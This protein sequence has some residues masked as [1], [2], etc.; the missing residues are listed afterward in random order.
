MD[1]SLSDLN[2]VEAYNEVISRFNPKQFVDLIES[3]RVT[4]F[5]KAAW[6]STGHSDPTFITMCRFLQEAELFMTVRYAIKHGDISILRR[7]V[8]P[9]IIMFL[10]ADQKNYAYEMMYY[11]WMLKDGVFTSVL[12]RSILV[13]RLVNWL[14]RLSIFKPIDLLVE[15]LNG[16]IKIEMKCYK[17]F[18]HN[19]NIAFHRVCTTNTIVRAIRSIMENEFGEEMSGAHTTA[20]LVRDVFNRACHLVTNGFTR[21]RVYS[22]PL[23][24]FQSA[25]IYT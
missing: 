10:G 3:V 4:A 24:L 22:L 23:N 25:D 16:F 12:Q 19:I 13:S 17:N 21:L 15:H 2:R 7:C 18:T 20:N 1:L 8:D 9:L 11:R 14:G 6:N 5:T